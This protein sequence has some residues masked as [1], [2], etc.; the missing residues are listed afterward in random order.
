MRAI[1]VAGGDTPDRAALDAAWPGWD[2]DRG[3]VV[4]ADRG[5]IAARELGLRPDLVVGD[6]DSLD[7]DEARRITRAGIPLETVHAEKDE[8]DTELAIHRALARGA[9]TIVIVGALGGP[10]IDHALANI[11]LL[12]MPALDGRSAVILDGSTRI[13]LLAAD[14]TDHELSLD[15]RVGDLVSLVPLGATAEGV[16]TEGLAW[17]L[18]DADLPF[19]P[20]R[21]VSNVRV[22][23]DARVRLRRGRL[24]VV[25]VV[26]GHPHAVP[27]DQG[28]PR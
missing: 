18:R 27:H 28:G 1:V 14:G 9:D 7:P 13:R 21:G 5:A 26:D 15:G 11:A 16:T 19:G 2:R 23:S 10:R 25:E 4:A 17:S 8:T 24:L 3:L 20:A 6:V 22:S 12:G